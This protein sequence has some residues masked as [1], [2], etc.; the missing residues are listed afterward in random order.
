MTVLRVVKFLHE[1]GRYATMYEIRKAAGVAVTRKTLERLAEL[2]VLVKDPVL[3]TYRLNEEN[4]FVSELLRF[5]K[6]VGYL[7]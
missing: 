5:L 4:E 2:G 6:R 7:E 3:L 1:S